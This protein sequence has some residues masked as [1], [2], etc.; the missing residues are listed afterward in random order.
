MAHSFDLG[1]AQCHTTL[2]AIAYAGDTLN[3]A[4]P[5]IDTLHAAINHQ[6]SCYPHYACGTD[7]SLV[8]GPIETPWTDNLMFVAHNKATK[9]LAVVIRGTTTQT[10][11]RFEDVPRYL[12][13]FPDRFHKARVSGPFLNGVS[14]MLHA[15]DKWHGATF[16]SFL[17]GFLQTN[18]VHEIV[19][20]GHSQGACL[21]PLMLLC[22]KDGIYGAPRVAAPVALRG[23][24]VAPPTTGSSEFAQMVDDTCNCWFIINPKDILPLGYNRMFDCISQGIPYVLPVVE[25]ETVRALVDMANLYITPSDWAQPSQQAI[26]EGAE[27]GSDFFT[28]IG[29]QH[30]P[31][32]YLAKLGAAGVGT[33]AP[34]AFPVS[35]SP[36]ITFP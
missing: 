14:A 18:T 13:H 9:T 19:V 15:K 20:S 29:E 4:S 3:G 12:R 17:N 6:L 23:Y 30:N 10:L 36:K 11:S 26:L 7:W 5:S 16:E 1:D 2:A 21:V 34:S 22:L 28:Q 35:K 24:A 8:W 31:N 33:D 25:R 27:T 32:A